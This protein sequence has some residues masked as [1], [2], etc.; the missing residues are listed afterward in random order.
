MQVTTSASC[1]SSR[2]LLVSADPLS[3]QFRDALAKTLDCVRRNIGTT[4]TILDQDCTG[5][6]N[7]ALPQ[8][9]GGVHAASKRIDPEPRASVGSTF[10]TDNPDLQRDAITHEFFHLLA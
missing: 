4:A 7:P 10:F 3:Q 5:R 2:R 6:S 1:F 8:T 9:G